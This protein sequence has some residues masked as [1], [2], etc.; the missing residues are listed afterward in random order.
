MPYIDPKKRS[1]YFKNYYAK[2][3]EYYFRTA[4]N[5]RKEHPEEFREIKAKSYRKSHGKEVDNMSNVKFK[6][7]TPHDFELVKTLTEAK[8]KVAKIAEIAQ[9]S[10]FTVNFLQKSSSY[11]DYRA[12]IKQYT[13]DYDAKRKLRKLNG[14]TE[15]SLP[16]KTALET[17]SKT[18]S[19][20]E[21]MSIIYALLKINATLE[22]LADAWETNPRKSFLQKITG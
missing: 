22:R 10:A 16:E 19:T 21:E 17:T 18:V 7:V 9:R 3:K 4:T 1:D 13:L 5:W 2:H 20:Q 15:S 14:K 6:Q 8:L 12:R 11:E